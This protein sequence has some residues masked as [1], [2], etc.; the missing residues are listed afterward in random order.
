MLKNGEAPMVHE[1]HRRSTIRN[2]I[3]GN[4]AIR[5]FARI[6]PYLEPVQLKERAVLQEPRK[7]IEH[8]HFIET[9]LV[10]LRTLATESILETAL[11]GR[12]GAVGVSV[13][14]GVE[15]NTV[16]CRAPHPA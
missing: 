10:S 6:R 5:E 9:G 14:L 13:A 3:L 7:R 4:L 11:V 16:D 12:Y 8:V 1:V 15:P 2:C